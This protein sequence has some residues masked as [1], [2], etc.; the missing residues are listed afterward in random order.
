MLL[1]L[2]HIRV[3]PRALEQKVLEILML[4]EIL[5]D[6]PL[7]QF[8]STQNPVVLPKH[9]LSLVPHAIL[10]IRQSGIGFN[11][12]ASSPPCTVEQIILLKR[13]VQLDKSVEVA[14]ANGSRL[15]L[16][17]D[18]GV[19]QLDQS[20]VPGI[21]GLC[22]ILEH[23]W[24]DLALWPSLSSTIKDGL[25]NIG[26]LVNLATVVVLG[27]QGYNAT[28]QINSVILCDR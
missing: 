13:G 25:N 24:W 9:L 17:F 6:F 11:K 27:E 15:Y 2:P 28:L 12:L 1:V 21:I 7:L 23:M 19:L 4:G 3:A 20:S 14:F 26:T 18:G 22:L 10:F 16:G 5:Q 8:L